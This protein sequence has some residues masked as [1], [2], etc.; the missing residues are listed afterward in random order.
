[1]ATTGA[2]KTW[3]RNILSWKPIFIMETHLS[4]HY[5][6]LFTDHEVEE[7]VVEVCGLD[8]GEAAGQQQQPRD[9]ASLRHTCPVLRE[10]L[11]E[12]KGCALQQQKRII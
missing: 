4:P 3:K 9:L 6:H 1:M 5:V 2:K 12:A 8:R 7:G 11:E 10:A